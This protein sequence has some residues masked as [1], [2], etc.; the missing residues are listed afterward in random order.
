MDLRRRDF[1][2]QGTLAAAVALTSC[3]GDGGGTG[4]VAVVPSTTATPAPSPS[5]SPTPTPTTTAARLIL[6]GDSRTEG[7]GAVAPDVFPAV[8]AAQLPSL[9]VINAGR[10]GQN[11]AQIVAR[12]GGAPALLTVAANTIPAAGPVM[13]VSASANIFFYAGDPNARGD[14]A[15]TLAGV[16]GICASDGGGTTSF[17]RSAAG[18]A[19]P[20]PAGTPFIPDQAVAERSSIMFLCAGRNGIEL[21]DPA[22]TVTLTA[23]AVA[24]LTGSPRYMVAGVMPDRG[25]RIGLPERIPYDRL[26]A[27]LQSRHASAYLDL[28]TPPSDAEMLAIG[29]TPD[30]SDR[31]DIAAGVFPSGMFQDATHLLRTGQAI[32]AGR[33]VA[34]IKTRGWA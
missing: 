15:G 14:I 9:T 27:A 2:A 30:V 5:P 4:G 31:A 21:E 6:W 12:Q 3:G 26:N 8:V 34:R 25:V 28:S 19:V 10:S 11:A 33:V 23:Q 7:I 24:Y 16:A 13:V 1:L 17:I 20:C 32:W 29:Y 18:N 22:E